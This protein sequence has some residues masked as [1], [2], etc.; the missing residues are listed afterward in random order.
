[1]KD[2]LDIR[3]DEIYR[4]YRVRIYR[5]IA[6]LAGR[7]QA[8][9]LTQDVFMKAGKSLHEFRGDAHVAT[10]LYRI[11]TNTV[12]DLRKSGACRKESAESPDLEAIA[13]MAHDRNLWT[14]DRSKSPDDILIRK[15]M[16]ECVRSIVDALPENDRI[17]IGLSDMEGF[18]DRE[19]AEI[20]NIKPGAAKIRLHRARTRLREKLEAACD[21]YRTRDN[22]L[23]CDKKAPV[24]TFRNTSSSARKK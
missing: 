22:T 23:A 5:Y 9:D 20:L 2:A 12:L 13:D 7:E 6:G 8:E 16:S 24:L 4:E 15:Q 1:M 14:K 3:L 21:F 10:W 11:A 19:I 18:S 17:I